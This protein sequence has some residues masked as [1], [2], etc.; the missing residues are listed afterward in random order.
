MKSLQ[1]PL[2]AEATGPASLVLTQWSPDRCGQRRRCCVCSSLPW[3]CAQVFRVSSSTMLLLA[4]RHAGCLRFA[5]DIYVCCESCVMPMSVLYKSKKMSSSSGGE[6]M[7]R[8]KRRIRRTEMLHATKAPPTSSS[9]HSRL[10][11]QCPWLYLQ[12]QLPARRYR[13]WWMIPPLH[14]A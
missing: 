8:G 5:V 9:P 4:L 2:L 13:R 10:H 3:R 11:E 1:A 12:Y 7:G 6:G 14:M